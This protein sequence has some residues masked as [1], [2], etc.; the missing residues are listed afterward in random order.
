MLIQDKDADFEL[1]NKILLNTNTATEQINTPVPPN[2]FSEPT[3]TPSNNASQAD[4]LLL[5]P[6][7]SV[8]KD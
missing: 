5:K 7:T 1:D 6:T 4:R 3:K 8:S 2:A